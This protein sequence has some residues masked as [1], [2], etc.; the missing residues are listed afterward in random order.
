MTSRVWLLTLAALLSL[1]LIA[2]DARAHAT[3]PALLQLEEVRAGVVDVVWKAPVVDARRSDLVVVLSSRCADVTP[4]VETRVPSGVVVRWTARCEGGLAG[5]TVAVRGLERG[6]EEAIL[7]ARLADDRHLTAALR[8]DAPETTIPTS[9]SS[10]TVARSYVGLGVEHIAT[11]LDH[12]AFVLGLVLLVGA[13]RRLLAAVTAFTFAHSITLALAALQIVMPRARLVEALIALSIVFLA[14]EIVR[15]H[16]GASVARRPFA[17]AFGFGLLHGFGFA[18]GLA[19]IGL[20]GADIPVALLS[21]NV[22]VELGQLTFVAL[23]LGIGAIARRALPPRAWLGRSAVA[24]VIGVLGAYWSCQR[25]T[26]F[27]A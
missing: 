11:G 6:V 26:A 4:R 18:S 10:V 13:P 12:L 14:A 15:P 21:F 7:R 9:P 27:W 2:R 8:S 19:E 22:G 17:F 24:Y 1:G 3:N 20:P 23:V 5:T 16:P 25:V